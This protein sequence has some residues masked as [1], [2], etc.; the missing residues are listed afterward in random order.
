MCSPPWH[1]HTP[2]HPS[3]PAH[4][5]LLL[6]L[7]GTHIHSVIHPLQP[8]LP[9]SLPSRPASTPSTPPAPSLPPQALEALRKLRTEKVHEVK[10]MKLR[11]DHTKT[12][13]EAAHRLQADLAQGKAKETEY[14]QQISGLKAKMQV[15]GGGGGGG[16]S[17]LH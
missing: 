2:R 11:L 14:L 5:P 1:T 3:P 12:H 13:Y 6:A 9:F 15:G 17:G 16:A 10:D 4:L 8:T 7:P